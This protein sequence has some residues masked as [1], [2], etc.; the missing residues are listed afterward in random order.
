MIILEDV[1]KKYGGRIVL[2]HLHLTFPDSGFLCVTGPSGIGKT[3]LLNLLLGLITPDEG[4]IRFSGNQA[5]VFSVVFQEDRLLPW[6]S[7][8]DNVLL[9]CLYSAIRPTDPRNLHC[10]AAQRTTNCKSRQTDAEAYEYKPDP[11]ADK[12]DGVSGKKRFSAEYKKQMMEKAIGLLT[13][14]GLKE[15]LHKL[16]AELSG[17]MARRVAIARALAADADVYL[18]DEPTKGLDD[19]TRRQ[20]LSVIRKYTDQAADAAVQSADVTTQ[21]ETIV[22]PAAD[23]ASGSGSRPRL[24][25]LITHN[26]EETEGARVISL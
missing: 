7:A 11:E 9:P 1:T 20:V 16:P 22:D 2:N 24:L 6:E 25:V 23:A 14:L 4:R 17:G 18:M 8:L 19:D 12:G 21:A 10:E 26:P 3:T 13:E 15:E 5:P